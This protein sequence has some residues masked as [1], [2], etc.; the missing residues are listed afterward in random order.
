MSIKKN[1]SK[2]F[3]LVISLS[4]ILMLSCSKNDY[5]GDLRI[6]EET[7]QH[8]KNL[9]SVTM[10]IDDGR[11]IKHF[12]K[13]LQLEKVEYWDGTYDIATYEDGLLS[14]MEEFDAQGKL[15]WT[16]TYQYD[17]MGRITQRMTTPHNAYTQYDI[18]EKK[19]AYQES[20]VDVTLNFYD[21]NFE[22]NASNKFQL[23]FD[24]NGQITEE[25]FE[26]IG[27]KEVIE[28]FEGNPK[29]YKQFKRDGTLAA[30]A[31]YKYLDRPVSEAYQFRK[32]IYGE[33]WKNNYILNNQFNLDYSTVPLI[34]DNFLSSYSYVFYATETRVS[35]QSEYEF[36]SDGRL[37]KQK[38]KEEFNNSKFNIEY[39]YEYSQ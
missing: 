7:A 3:V 35:Y 18:R 4:T 10:V 38:V 8:E 12:F 23:T 39:L 2:K 22:L 24:E 32:Y 14:K 9:A 17:V 36:D 16:N 21:A 34:S 33:Q 20:V 31:E 30:D 27:E 28:Y 26:D 29:G 11:R 5:S 15:R 6:A 25:L 37:A 13:D 19:F 1:S